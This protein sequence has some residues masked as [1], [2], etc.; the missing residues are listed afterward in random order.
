MTRSKRRTER[1][2][3]CDLQSVGVTHASPSPE[4]VAFRKVAKN[5]AAQ[6][7]ILAFRQQE[8]NMRGPGSPLPLFRR[9]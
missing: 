8:A 1:P 5:M 3:D 9:R 4:S 6:V 7:S 2:D